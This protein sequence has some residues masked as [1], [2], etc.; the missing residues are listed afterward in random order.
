[1]VQRKSAK[2]QRLLR[3]FGENV[4]RWRKVNGLT[5]S[6]LAERAFITRET[7][8]N[9]EQ[10]TGAPRLDSVISVLAALGIADGVV[11]AADPYR[12]TA[13]RIRIDEI[14]GNGGSV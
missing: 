2:Q 11:Q 1:M 12:S 8:R 9:L 3:E 4:A 7:L 10:G 6:E 5:S 13:G 14:I